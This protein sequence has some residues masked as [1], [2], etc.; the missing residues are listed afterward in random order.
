MGSPWDWVGALQVGF[1]V[2]ITRTTV[3]GFTWVWKP[4]LLGGPNS[5]G[6]CL[7]RSG[8]RVSTATS[9]V[10][11][12]QRKDSNIIV[13]H[14]SERINSDHLDFHTIR[15]R[16]S[17]ADKVTILGLERWLQEK[18]RWPAWPQYQ[19]NEWICSFSKIYQKLGISS[20]S[21][22]ISAHGSRDAT[23]R[24]PLPPFE[25]PFGQ[26]L[27]CFV[28]LDQTLV[29]ATISS[30]GSW[31]HNVRGKSGNQSQITAEDKDSNE[32]R[33][34]GVQGRWSEQLK[35]HLEGGE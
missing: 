1:E 2:W 31:V 18:D 14:M 29:R 20:P 26:Q 34:E 27:N 19:Q 4:N 32:G 16:R 12:R 28:Q 8:F 33:K 5:W 9:N 11:P 3:G 30:N 22:L 10:N 25:S 17:D 15:F 7:R 6:K 21:M 13:G 24:P 35:V 23:S